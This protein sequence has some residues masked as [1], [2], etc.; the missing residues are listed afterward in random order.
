MPDYAVMGLLYVFLKYLRLS[1][2]FMY[3][4]IYMKCED[5]DMYKD[6]LAQCHRGSIMTKNNVAIPRNMGLTKNRDRTL[7]FRGTEQSWQ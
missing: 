5:E 3:L 6:R 2:W 4:K 7:R 1:P